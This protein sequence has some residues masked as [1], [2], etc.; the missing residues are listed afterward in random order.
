VQGVGVDTAGEDLA[1][2]RHHG[3]VGAG[4][5]GDRVEQDDDVLL[6]LDEAL[7]LLDDHLGD[8]HVALR[9]LVEG[10]ADDLALAPSAA[11]R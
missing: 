1:R 4:E 6:V 3:V 8:L 9:R 11:C 10:R 5:A 7:G 2:R